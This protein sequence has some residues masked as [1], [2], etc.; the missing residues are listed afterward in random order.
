[1]GLLLA[2]FPQSRVEFDAL[3]KTAWYEALH[4]LDVNFFALAV[5]EI[6]Q[7]S[8]FF[9]SIAEIRQVAAKHKEIASAREE[10]EFEGQVMSERAQRN[11]ALVMKV[12]A[13]EMTASEADNLFER[14][15]GVA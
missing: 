2:S 7:T 1:M 3:V 12:A 15:E 5:K 10:A 8:R 13:G 6:L 11:M 4:D 9:P 14:E